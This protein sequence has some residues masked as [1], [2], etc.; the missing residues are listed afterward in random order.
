MMTLL[1]KDGWWLGLADA[2]ASC[3]WIVGAMV[4]RQWLILVN[5]IWLPGGQ[6]WL[7]SQLPTACGP[8]YCS[9]ELEKLDRSKQRALCQL[10]D[11]MLHQLYRIQSFKPQGTWLCPWLGDP[12]FFDGLPAKMV[13]S[14]M[15]QGCRLDLFTNDFSGCKAKAITHSWPNTG[16]AGM[17]WDF[18]ATR[19]RRKTQSRCLVPAVYGIV[20]HGPGRPRQQNGCQGIHGATNDDTDEYIHVNKKYEIN[21]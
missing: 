13:I 21:K 17:R 15:V 2:G 19:T 12:R 6:R 14:G 9:L 18:G 1:T 16:Q 3:W 20:T 4:N 10:S 7:A 8:K 5:L 11:H